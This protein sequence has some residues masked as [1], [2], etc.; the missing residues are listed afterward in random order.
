MNQTL[1]G[2][3]LVVLLVGFGAGTVLAQSK[4]MTGA[5]ASSCGQY[6]E[7]R[8]KN[9]S[10]LNAIF[11]SWIQGFVSAMNARTYEANAP[12]RNLPESA[13][14]LAYTDKFC[15]ENPLADVANGAHALYGDLR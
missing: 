11:A 2:T 14:L 6:L 8:A 4:M 3:I 10:A 13:T 15:R 5:G 9:S 7:A 12:I 1:R